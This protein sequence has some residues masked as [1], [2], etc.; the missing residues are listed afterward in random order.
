[1]CCCAGPRFGYGKLSGIGLVGDAMNSPSSRSMLPVA[2]VAVATSLIFGSGCG[3]SSPVQVASQSA[4]HSTSAAG[5]AS[6]TNLPSPSSAILQTAKSYTTVGPLVAVQQADIAAERD[7]RV[8]NIA[9]Q[10]G[11][12]VQKGQVLALLD[13]NMLRASR[14]AQKARVASLQAQVQDWQAEQK[15]VEADLHRADTML[16]DKIISR[17]AWEHVK[18][19]LDETVAEVAR[20]RADETVA[21]DE[22]E[23]ANLQLE[24]SRIVAPFAGVV[25]RSSVRIA[26]QVKEGDVLFWI[27][28]VAPLRILFTVPESA[29][30][31]FTNGG[32]LVLTTPDYPSLRQPAR[33]LRVSPVV[34][35]ASGSVQI[36]GAVVHPSALLKPGMSMQVRLAP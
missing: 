14:D 22:L 34:D 18:Y 23:A 24:K 30:A 15:S 32:A 26:Q 13:D 2:A 8:V 5:P 12:H 16:A 21:E 28:A 9:V 10:I 4:S 6:A 3:A 29:M 11:D 36:I 31:A 35:P 7:G 17:E 33:I 1:M 19:K 27:T 25:G 20:H